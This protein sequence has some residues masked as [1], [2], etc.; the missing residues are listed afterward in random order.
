MPVFSIEIAG[1]RN[2]CVLFTPTGE[3]IRGRWDFRNTAHR[4]LGEALKHVFIA[5]PIIPGMILRIDTD[6]RSAK[7]IDPLK[8]TEE[9]KAILAKI[10]AVFLMYKQVFGGP[11]EAHETVEYNELTTDQIKEWVFYIRSLLDN[12]M[13]T[14]IPGSDTP[15]TLLQIR[16]EW[17]GK[18]RKDPLGNNRD[19]DDDS[20]RF[21]DEVKETRRPATAGKS[22]Q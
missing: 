8:E 4:D 6:A 17:P 2:E 10:N 7:R 12:K 13:A 20:T 5:A 3:T 21:V 18:R 1:P 14:L 22:E 15:P 19:D 16:K 9:G 11:K